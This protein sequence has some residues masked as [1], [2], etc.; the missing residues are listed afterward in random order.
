MKGFIFIVFLLFTFNKLA[1][2]QIRI[3]HNDRPS[4]L[5]AK[6]ALPFDTLAN[7][8]IL[9]KFVLNHDTTIINVFNRNVIGIVLFIPEIKIDFSLYIIPN[10]TLDI[11]LINDT[12]T[13]NII[14]KYNIDYVQL[15]TIMK[16]FTKTYLDY[17]LFKKINESAVYDYFSTEYVTLRKKFETENVIVTEHYINHLLLTLIG[18]LVRKNLMVKAE[19]ECVSKLIKM[20]NLDKNI[21]SNLSNYSYFYYL[22]GLEKCKINYT[23]KSEYFQNHQFLFHIFNETMRSYILK[24]QFILGIDAKI[25]ELLKYRCDAYSD[26]KFASQFNNERLD[27]ILLS[28]TYGCL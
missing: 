8:F 16:E 5:S 3:H 19:N 26:I 18:S 28:Y 11:Y 15:G 14:S 9:D 17:F 7:A 22:S 27:N 2:T 23:I 1:A 25:P 10:D 20:Y 13:I 24:L 6:L 4:T 21:F 12:K